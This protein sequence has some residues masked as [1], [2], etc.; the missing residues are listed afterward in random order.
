VPMTV[1]ETAM[2]EGWFN[3]KAAWRRWLNDRDNRAFR[4]WGGQV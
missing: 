4:V 1:V 2:R 3:D